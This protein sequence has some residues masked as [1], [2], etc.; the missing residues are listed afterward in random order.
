MRASKQIDADALLAALEKIGD[1]IHAEVPYVNHGG[2]AI[3]AAAVA[4][5]IKRLGLPVDIATGG[6]HYTKPAAV[7]RERVADPTDPY[8]WD[9]AGLGRGHLAVRFPLGDMAYT[10]DT[11]GFAPDDEPVLGGSEWEKNGEFGTGLTIEEC[12]AMV[13]RK[14]GWNPTFDRRHVP[15]IRRIVREEFDTLRGTE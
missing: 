4:R 5:R 15:T 13:R 12:T 9:R 11:N 14:R 6:Y 10:W 7:V 8:E 1:R 2:C 3:V